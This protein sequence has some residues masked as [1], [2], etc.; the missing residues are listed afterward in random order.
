MPE[1]LKQASTAARARLQVRPTQPSESGATGLQPLKLGGN[2][3]GFLYVPQ[4]YRSDRPAPLI[5]MLHGAGGDAEGALNILQGLANSFET[6]LLAVDSRDRSWDVIVGQY[7]PDI[8]FIDQALAQ[9]FNRYAI[10]PSQIAIAG[11]SDGASYALS[12][13]ITNGDLFNH[14]IAFSPGFA[15]PRDQIGTPKVF[16]SHGTRDRVLPIDRCSRRIVPVLQQAGYEVNYQE[17]DGGHTVPG[18]IARTALEW[19]TEAD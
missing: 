3:D 15:A 13:G 8:I 1:S 12:V 4:H 2:R 11:F 18:A 10:D 16:I 7:G 6:I 14:V 19:F 9:T 5:L 17:F